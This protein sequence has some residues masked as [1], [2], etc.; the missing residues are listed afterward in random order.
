MAKNYVKLAKNGEFS[1]IIDIRRIG[2]LGR[3]FG[4]ILSA[5]FGRIFGIGRILLQTS[6]NQKRPDLDSLQSP[7][8]HK[9]LWKTKIMVTKTVVTIFALWMRN[10]VCLKTNKPWWIFWLLE[11]FILPDFLHSRKSFALKLFHVS[12]YG[13]KTFKKCCFFLHF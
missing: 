6:A 3:I 8:L 1:P 2:Q 12:L 4:Q 7:G 11:M 13:T 5:E 10:Y 9:E